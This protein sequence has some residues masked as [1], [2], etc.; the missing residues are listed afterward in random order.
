MEKQTIIERLAKD[1]DYRTICRNVAG[2]YAEDLYQDLVL[3]LLEMPEEKLQQLEQTCLKCFFYRM[4]QRQFNSKNSR[5]YR[6]YLRDGEALKSR[7]A[8]IEAACEPSD[9]NQEWIDKT[10]KALKEID[11]YDAGIMS[12]YAQE[13]TLRAVSEK[14]GIPARSIQNTVTLAKRLIRKK[15]N[16]YE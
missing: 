9:I 11:W 8:D 13:G 7:I 12:L 1:E 5:F 16:K 6:T 2:D 3:A 15:V 10:L 14:T 4:A